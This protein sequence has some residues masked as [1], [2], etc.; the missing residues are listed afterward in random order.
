[1]TMRAGALLTVGW[2]TGSCGCT[3]R[4]LDFL[5]TFLSRI[6]YQRKMLA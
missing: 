6:K 1:M 2:G 5:D 4:Q 3:Y